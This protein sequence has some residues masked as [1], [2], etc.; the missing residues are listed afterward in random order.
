MR[1]RFRRSVSLVCGKRRYK[2]GRK[3]RRPC[4]PSGRRK[5]RN[6][7]MRKRKCSCLIQGNP[8]S[9]AT[10][11]GLDWEK[12]TE[13]WIDP[14][15]GIIT[16]SCGTRQNPVLEREE[17]HDGIDIAVAEGT[18]VAAVKSGVVTETRTSATLGRLVKF[19]TTDGYDVMYAHLS[20]ILVKK[21]EE[22]RQGQAVAR[23]GNTG[24][25][26]GPH[27]HYSLTRCL[28]LPCAIRRRCGRN[29]RRGTK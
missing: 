16:S 24:L 23:S 21:G 11:A 10:W 2:S 12:K 17:L 8:P 7:W 26:T 19:R 20:E 29:M 15:Q 1:H 5:R 18:E 25:S 13:N 22:I 27:L 6:L 3:K 9:I 28:S 14:L 4:L